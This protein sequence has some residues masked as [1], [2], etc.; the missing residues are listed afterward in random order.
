[1]KKL[2]FIIFAAL[3]NIFMIN[4]VSAAS[5]TISVSAPK[6]TLI[7]GDTVT[8]TVKVS[9]SSNLGAWQFDVGY[10][11]LTFVSSSTGGLSIVDYGPIKSKTY[12]FKFKAKSSGTASVSIKNYNVLDYDTTSPMTVT[13]GKVN[14]KCM[15]QSELQATYSKN[16]YLSSLTV[17]DGVLSPEFNKNTQEYTVELENKT[18]SITVKATK[19]DSK[20]S[21]KGTGTVSLVE[22]NN[23]IN[24]VV[25]AQN[26]STRTYK[27]NAIVKELNPIEVTLNDNKYLVVR[28]EELLPEANVYFTKTTIKINEEDVPAYY[29][30]VTSMTLVGLTD[31]N[32]ETNLYIYDSGEYTLFEEVSFNQISLRILEMDETLLKDE[33]EKIKLDISGKTVLSYQ[34]KDSEY[35]L[36]YGLNLETGEKNI[37]QYDVKENTVQRYIETIDDNSLYYIIILSIIGFSLFTYLIFIILIIRNNKITKKLTA[38]IEK[39]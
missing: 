26:G 6:S 5:A 39:N 31:V 15:T 11:N 4:N 2:K 28:K 9:S 10:S 7:V 1:M 38:K 8:V 30:E 3:I 12:T 27:I 17:S 32:G 33:Y 23:L 18:E 34:K 35:Y 22:G 20:S 19:D 29:N 16:N 36:I 14:F 37:Y 25:T 21:V 13:V 24:V